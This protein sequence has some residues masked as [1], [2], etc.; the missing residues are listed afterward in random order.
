METLRISLDNLQNKIQMGLEIEGHLKKKVYDLEKE[1]VR[2]KFR[3]EE[4]MEKGIAGLLHNHSQLRIDI[5]NLLDEG[6]SHLKSTIDILE[7]KIKQLRINGELNIIPPRIDTKLQESECPD[8]H[9]T[10]DA[11]S[12]LVTKTNF[13]GLPKSFT[14]GTGDDSEALAQA[15]Q[16]KVATLLLLSQQEERYL[17]ESNVNAAL[18][19][20][21][22]EFQI[23][24]LQVTNE[25]VKALMEL[26][27]LK[28]EHRILQEKVNLDMKQGKHLADSEEKSVVQD[29]DG[30]LKNMLKKTYLR[31]WINPLDSN[32]SEA[33]ARLDYEENISSKSSNYNMDFAR[34]K[35]ENAALK[36]SLESMGH[37]TSSL[38]RLRLSLMKVKESVTYEGTV[39]KSEEL[40]NIVSE[41]KLVK[42]ALGSSLP[43]SWLAEPD[44]SSS[45]EVEEDLVVSGDS[46]GEKV[47]WV[48]AAGFEMVELLIFAAQLLMDEGLNRSL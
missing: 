40:E 33:E 26:A 7:D 14:V 39:R 23:N 34:M 4:K 42:T 24:L 37:L 5:K 18:Q 48:S 45:N 3:L 30:R 36:E 44:V 31:R 22:E 43:V 32:L 12:D 17:L 27:Q 25:K 2:T 21:L 28:Q 1:K 19:K 29:R 8:V 6:Y 11:S 13:S 47:D 38:H 46:S 15:L 10:T 41:A 35:I 9:V 20:K 16:E